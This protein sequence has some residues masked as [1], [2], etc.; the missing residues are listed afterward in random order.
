MNNFGYVSCGVHAIFIANHA[1]KSGG[2]FIQLRNRD[3]T[4]MLMD[5][6]FFTNVYSLTERRGAPNSVDHQSCAPPVLQ[7]QFPT[8]CFLLRS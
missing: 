6:H 4:R 7:N 3:S 8:E 2:H 1:D 5:G